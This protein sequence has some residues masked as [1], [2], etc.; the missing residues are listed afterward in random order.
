MTKSKIFVTGGSGKAG[1]HLIP[2]LLDS[3]T[4]LSFVAVL[5]FANLS[6]ILKLPNLS[7]YFVKAFCIALF[8]SFFRLD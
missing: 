2:Y 6:P 8:A 3:S 7:G 4:I 5:Y 1:K